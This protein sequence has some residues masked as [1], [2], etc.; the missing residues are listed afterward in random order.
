MITINALAAADSDYPNN[1]HYLSAEGL[2][3]FVRFVSMV[4]RQT[5]RVAPRTDGISNDG[6]NAPQINI[7]KEITA[8]V[9]ACILIAQNH[10][11]DTEI[12]HLIR[13][14]EATAEGKVFWLHDKSGAR[15][16]SSD[17]ARQ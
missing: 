11:F 3:P 1:I 16:R 14:V 7:S 15:L 10:V 2:A 12:S 4:K 6:D 13:V 5:N 9:K 8:T 17:T